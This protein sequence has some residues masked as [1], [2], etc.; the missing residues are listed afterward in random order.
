MKDPACRILASKRR[1]FESLAAHTGYAIPAGL[2]YGA[3]ASWSRGEK[4]SRKGLARLLIRT[5]RGEP[6]AKIHT[7]KPPANRL[8]SNVTSASP[9]IFRRPRSCCG[10]RKGMAS[11]SARGWCNR[12]APTIPRR[13]A[14]S[15]QTNSSCGCAPEQ[16]G[17]PVARSRSVC[18]H[19]SSSYRCRRLYPGGRMVR[20]YGYSHGGLR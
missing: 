11:S 1:R 19:C 17:T 4:S 20:R 3:L 10:V 7:R 8:R 6:T 12:I 9:P 14:L 16:T 15:P 2:F 5:T 18:L 13:P